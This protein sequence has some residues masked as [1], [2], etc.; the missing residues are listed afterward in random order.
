MIVAL[1]ALH[2]QAHPNRGRRL[3]AINGILDTKLF[4]DNAAFIGRSVVAIEAGGDL[5]LDGSVGQQVARE[6]LDGKLVKWFVR[7]VGTDNPIAPRPH[8][9]RSVSM[10]DATVTITSCVQP[11]DGHSFAVVGRS[12]Q[13]V[14][15]FFVCVRAGVG[16]EIVDLPDGRWQASQVHRDAAE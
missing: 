15:D 3:D 1:S 11:D 10:K 9:T 2:G 12:Q 16:D 7:V 13:S 6:L 5:L 14:N 4:R 8:I